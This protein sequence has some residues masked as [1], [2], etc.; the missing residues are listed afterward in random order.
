M[1]NDFKGSARARPDPLDAKSMPI[2]KD[3]IN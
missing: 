3:L 1:S 2:L